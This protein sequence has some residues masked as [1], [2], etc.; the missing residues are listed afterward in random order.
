MSLLDALLEKEVIRPLDWHF[1]RWLAAQ[2]PSAQ[3]HHLLMAALVSQQLGEG[4][5]CVDIRQL[6]ACWQPGNAI[7]QQVLALLAEV[8][9][10]Q[11]LVAPLLGD[12]TQITPLVYDNQRIYLYRYWQAERQ[13]AKRLQRRAMP[14]PVNADEVSP[15]LDALFLQGA[16]Q[17]DWQ[18]VA[19]LTAASRSV[20][21][22]S[23]GPGTGKTTTV[24]RMLAIYIQLVCAQQPN[25]PP[26]IRLAAP[27][28]KAAARLSESIAQAKAALPVAESV[29]AL[30]PDQGE[31]LHRLL[32]ARPG[33]GSFRHHE[34]NPLHVDMLV[35]DEASMIDLPM[36]DSLLAALPQHARLV[37]IGDKQQLASVEAGSVL[38]DLCA[39]PEGVCRTDAQQNLLQ[40][41]CQVP[42]TSGTA[43]SFADS[44]AFLQHSYRFDARSGIGALA[45]AI[46]EGSGARVRAVLKQGYQDL[47]YLPTGTGIDNLLAHMQAEYEHFFQAIKS[48]ASPAQVL[49]AMSRFQVLC[50][51]RR[52]MFG[53]VAVNE[54]FEARLQQQGLIQM[55]GRWYAG[56]P[57]M[58]TRNDPSLKLY[59]G[60]MGVALPEPDTGR[61]QVWFETAGTLVAYSTSRLPQHETVYAMTVHKSQG[62]EFKRV[63]L[64]VTDAAQ[65]ISREL[66]YTGVTR[67]K[68]H[69][70]VFGSLKVLCQAAEQPTI[71]MSGLAERIWQPAEGKD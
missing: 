39:Y 3:E 48:G 51:L 22:I 18:R 34:D 61:L 58:I 37:L 19:A 49:E 43:V 9:I 46:N 70:T 33:Q 56:R 10:S 40:T 5:V 13:V 36:M 53:V 24:T 71:R 35:V 38:G 11:W 42:K 1:A 64:V 66:V 8:E 68:Q 29:K 14:C 63:T 47:I 62:S 6:Q 7:T 57:V 17:P 15:L 65:V 28:G 23:G 16:E 69:C 21:L 67:A 55:Q 12:G 20:A 27:T 4:H 59:N 32:G 44:V 30:I 50:G 54:A 45:S 25:K 26:L 41:T 52:G 2:H 60:D 31:T